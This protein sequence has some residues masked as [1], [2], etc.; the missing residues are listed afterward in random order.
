MYSIFGNKVLPKCFSRLSSLSNFL[1]SINDRSFKPLDG[2]M[3]FFSPCLSHAS[4]ISFAE[5]Y[6][7][8]LNTQGSKVHN[9]PCKWLLGNSGY[10]KGFYFYKWYK[11]HHAFCVPWYGLMTIPEG[12]QEN[13]QRKLFTF[14]RYR[15]SI[16][17]F[18]ISLYKTLRT[19]CLYLYVILVV[20]LHRCGLNNLMKLI[21]YLRRPF[22]SNSTG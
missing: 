4:W 6:S 21:T 1:N 5:L 13:S 22:M 14:L 11:M 3:V 17:I 16:S 9:S 20:S 12:I 2:R 7:P 8:C 10:R 15:F 18:N 19:F